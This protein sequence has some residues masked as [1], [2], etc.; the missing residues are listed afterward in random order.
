MIIPTK[1]LDRYAL[2][3]DLVN[4]CLVSRQDRMGAYEQWRNYYLWGSSLDSEPA[5]YNKIEPAIDLFTSFVFAGETTKFAIELGDT[6]DFDVHGTKVDPMK[7]RLNTNWHRWNTDIVFSGGLDWSCAF[8]SMILKFVVRGNRLVPYLIEPH[9]FGVLNESVA[10]LDDQEAFCH[11]Y[12]V[13]VSAFK[14][15]ISDHPRRHEIE[16]SVAKSM[17]ATVHDGPAGVQRILMSTFPMAG[18]GESAGRVNNLYG[19]TER[20]RARVSEETVEMRELWVWNDAIND[21]QI[22]NIDSGGTTIYDRRNFFM[23]SEHPCVMV[24]PV[25]QYDYIWG[26][27]MI[28][29]LI[30]LQ[31]LREVRLAQIR[32]LLDRQVKPPTSQKGQWQGPPDEIAYAMQVFGAGVSTS[33]PTADFKAW[34]PNVPQDTFTE[35]REIDA[36]FDEKTGLPRVMQGKGESG[37]RSRSQTSELARLGSSR[38]KKKAYTLEDALEKIG[39]LMVRGMQTYDDRPMIQR[40]HEGKVVGKFIA[41]QFPRDFICK[42][43]GHSSSPIFVEDHKQLSF[44]LFQARAIDR[45][46]LI[47]AVDPPNKQQ[48]QQGLRIMEKREV[49]AQQ[50]QAQAEEK[51]ER[52]KLLK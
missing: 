50:A 15:M 25:W 14:R 51:K 17:R 35:V 24:T 32:E 21:Y 6:V 18:T 19:V 46:E 13:G 16:E 43:D 30:N 48:L 20:Y 33:D 36:M 49:A 29:G 11:S 31:D 26:R 9:N 40:D 38:T 28:D 45:R 7:T 41:E 37:V 39:Y 4:A 2:Y 52:L 10:F 8:G 47:D 27:S 44:D 1:A 3:R 12:T 34:Y 5:V 23:E 22:A 42:V